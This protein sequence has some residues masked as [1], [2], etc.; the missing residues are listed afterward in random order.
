MHVD[1]GS[2]RL[3]S[4]RVLVVPYRQGP[5]S[6]PEPGRVGSGRMYHVMRGMQGRTDR[7]QIAYEAPHH[8]WTMSDTQI[9]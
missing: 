3:K 1:I 5:N 6:G 9:R 7:L 4:V 8:T 2:V